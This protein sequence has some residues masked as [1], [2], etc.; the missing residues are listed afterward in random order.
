MEVNWNISC[1]FV[2]QSLY[3]AFS[4]SFKRLREK[5][6][7]MKHFLLLIYMPSYQDDALTTTMHGTLETSFGFTMNIH[8]DFTI[9][10]PASPQTLLLLI[11]CCADHT[12]QI[13]CWHNIKTKVGPQSTTFSKSI[14]YSVAKYPK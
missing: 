11:T 5:D 6:T 12:L 8:I 7:Q 3:V 13:L 4:T 1:N 14:L 2:N 10:S 9:C